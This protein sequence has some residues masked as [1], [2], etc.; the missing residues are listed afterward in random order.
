[1]ENR[2]EFIQKAA[3]LASGASFLGFLPPAIQQALAIDPQKGSTYLDAEHVVILMQENRSFDHAYGTLKGV[4]GFNDPRAITLPNKN[5]V[6][7]QTDEK[8]DTFGPFRLNIKDTN[9]TWMSSLP[10]SWED[11]TR[12][13]NEGKYDQWLQQKKSGNTEFKKMPLTLGHY[14]R[15]DIPFYYALADAFTICDQNF[16]SSLTGTTPN[17]LY[18]W[19]GTVRQEPSFESKANVKNSDAD[20]GNWAHWKT[21]P[22]RL[23]EN[24]ISWK[25]YQNELS[26]TSGLVGEE[27]AWLAN[28]TDNAIEFFD[29]YKVKFSREYYDFLVKNLPLLPDEIKVLNAKLNDANAKDYKSIKREIENKENLLKIGTEDIVTYHPDNFKK[30]PDFQQSIHQ[31]AFTNN[32]NDPSY[33]SLTSIE[34]DDNGTKRTVQVPRG[35]VLHQF[36]EDVNTGNLPT[37]SWLVA[38]ENFSDHPGAPWYGSW[39]LSEVMDI[40]TKDPEVWKKTIFI[41]CYDENDGYFDHVPPF[42]AP[43]MAMPNQGKVSAGIDTAVE[44]VNIVHEKQRPYKNPE[45]EAI[46]GPIGLGFRVPL[47][48]A[49]PWSRGGQVNSEVFDHTS[50]LQFLEHF[51]S[52]KTGKEIKETNISDWRRT[53]CGDLTSVFTPFD[54]KKNTLE[55]VQKNEFITTV[56]KAQFKKLPEYKVLA[57]HE[58]EAI[59]LGKTSIGDLQESGVKQ[60]CA[61][62]YLIQS[63]GQLSA[64]AQLFEISMGSS[65]A[66]YGNKTA[67]VP[68][69]VY[70][71]NYEKEPLRAWNYAVKNTDKL[72]D[73]WELSKFANE[74]YQLQVYGPNGFFREFKGNAMDPKIEISCGY[75]KMTEKGK[76]LSGNILLTINNLDNK[77]YTIE[78]IDNAYQSKKATQSITKAGG[79]RSRV[80]TIMNLAKSHN[81]YDFSVKIVGNAVFEKRFAGHVETG[82]SSFTDPLMG[83]MV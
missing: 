66:I 14:N 47:L 10:H 12:A 76:S 59:N 30:L 22:E 17:R 50:I 9:A 29:Q 70:A 33:H 83:K 28:F 68:F 60:A 64:N 57:A 36:R 49:S 51:L 3:L 62:P 41:L 54:G 34:Y 27:D 2:R 56:H 44:Q 25:I 6:W 18:L 72:T 77:A 69:I 38:P 24:D 7:L 8:G 55:F 65:T 20:Y 42:V 5:K 73:T 15:E 52:K 53:I 81:W 45:K 82:K 61:L 43:N 32:R 23:E 80:K 13:R 48:I 19:S 46:D 39:Y 37:V 4:R 63:N 75:Q 58:V 71:H 74:Q 35:D 79:A 40:L 67:G 26:V 21:F 1:M 78:I 31:K 16:C 11:Q